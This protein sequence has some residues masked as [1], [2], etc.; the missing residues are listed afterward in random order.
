MQTL[1]AAGRPRLGPALLAPEHEQVG[2]AEVVGR[3]H[4]G[5]GA[6]SPE[7]RAEG[8]AVQEHVALGP[9]AREQREASD[10]EP[11]DE[12]GHRRDR[13]HP[14]EGPHRLHVLLVVH[15]MDDRAGAEEQESLV[16]GVREHEEDGRVVGADP[17][18]EE[19]VAQLGDRRIGEDLL[20]VVL[21]TGDRRPQQRRRRPDYG[22][23]VRG[24]R[25]PEEDGV[26]PAHQVDPGRDHRGGVDEG[27]DGRRAFHGVRQPG[28]ERDLGRL[29]HGAAEQQQPDGDEGGLAHRGEVGEHGVVLETAG[30]LVDEE[31]GDEEGGVADPVEDHRLFGRARGAVALEPEADEEVGAD[32]HALPAEEEEQEVVRQHEQQHGGDEEVQVEEELREV[33]VVL[34]VADRVEV[35]EGAHPRH[36]GRHR[37]RERVDEKA[38]VDVEMT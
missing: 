22:D 32:A 31:Q 24:V 8:E 23:D 2:A 6:H 12:E 30:A 25:R 20:D 28:I 35:D 4:R 19:H 10:G 14:G 1:S 34:H 38:H 13:H 7:G 16:E 17:R 36:E 33:L 37:H 15:G 21:G 29:A 9:K 27:R 26:D 5:E 11:S 3:Q 18:G